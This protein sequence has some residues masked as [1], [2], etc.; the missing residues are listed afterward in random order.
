MT[1]PRNLSLRRFLLHFLRLK[2]GIKQNLIMAGNNATKKDLAAKD[3]LPPLRVLP[4][5]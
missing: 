2:S 5:I 4:L 3:T 1:D